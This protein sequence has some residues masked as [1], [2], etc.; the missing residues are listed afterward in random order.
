MQQQRLFDYLYDQLRLYP[1]EKAFGHKVD[2]QWRYCSTAEM[3]GLVNRASRGLL[4]LG[5]LPGDK[6][7]T[8]VYQ[9]SPAWVALEI[10]MN[11]IGVLNVPMYP[12]ISA[13]EYA[14]ILHESE[15]QYCFVGSG[16]L[17]DKVA[18][19]QAQLPG[20]KEIFSFESHP[21]ARHWEA[22]LFPAP[23]QGDP[24]NWRYP[25]VEQIK[26]SI[27]PHAVMTLVYTSGTT[28]NPKG[29][30]LNHTNVVF[31]IESLRHMMDFQPGDRVLSFLPV[32]HIFERVAVYAFLA[33]GCSVSFTGTDNLGGD[34]GDLKAIRPHYFTTVPRLLE[35]VYDKI[36]AKGMELRGLK[37][38]L[39]FWALQ[40]TDHWYFDYQPRGL[41]W[42]K[43]RI[44]DRLI[45][46]KWRAALGGSVKTIITGAS[47]C[48]LRVM[49]TFNA[50]GIQ[51][52]EGYG[53]TE[54][55]PALS[56][57]K[58]EPGGALLGTVGPLMNGVEVRLEPSPEYQPGEGEIIASS[59]GVMLGYYKQPEKTAEVLTEAGGKR[60]MATGDVG[61]FVEANGKK[62]LKITD[63]KKELLKTSHG[64]YIAPAPIETALKEHYL[65]E[66]AM[67]VGDDFNYVTALIVP[68]EEGLRDWCLRH[69]L[70]WTSRAEML[71]HPD[72][73]RR[74]QMLLDRINPQLSKFE[75]VKKFSLLPDMWEPVK[76]DG[77]EAELTPTMKLKRRVI[78]EK[79]RAEIAAMYAG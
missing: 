65:V 16:D 20:L 58:P 1:L 62:Y 59:P 9:T 5:L 71:R 68:A 33:F 25:E 50:A 78:L 23:D 21:I 39:F 63:R 72:V 67:V 55:A 18:A 17:Y 30:M 10:A 53:M 15:A 44:A 28:G 46:S 29:V 38:A 37:R 31:N 56:F 35:K 13:R 51:V 47:A 24:A 19:A 43:W 3:V 57:S 76:T 52:R 6:V 34:S 48:P 61:A 45:F 64:K 14:Y 26:N 60:W 42:L 7:A 41:A 70:N 12:T 8:V 4:E 36:I 69:G 11:Q 54:V 74:Y 27:D 73:I 75:Q 2:G 49:R 40:L 32:S 79:F 66:Q 77:S 22:L